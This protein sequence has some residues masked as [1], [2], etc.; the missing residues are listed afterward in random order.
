MSVGV[1]VG[2]YVAVTVGV[3]V[4]LDV[5]V[6]VYVAVTVSEVYV[7]VAVTGGPMRSNCHVSLSG[8]TGFPLSSTTLTLH[9]NLPGPRLSWFA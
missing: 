8:L 7:G 4:C 2:V 6:G 5:R 3:F 1:F 9:Q